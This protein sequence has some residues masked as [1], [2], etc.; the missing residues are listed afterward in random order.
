MKLQDKVTVITGAGS[1]IG[2]EMALL[3]SSEGSA[4]LAA[5][6]RQEAVDETARMMRD[7]M[8]DARIETFQV[9]VTNWEQ[10]QAMI[11]KAIDTFGRVDILCNNAGIGHI[12]DVLKV[13]E[14]TFDRVMDVNV[15]GPFWGTKA[16]VPH[17]LDR[18]SGIIINTA[19][20]AG[21][22]GLPERAIYCTSKGAVIALTKQVA[23]QYA[24]KGI[25]CN[26]ICPGTVDTP[27]VEN[28]LSQA[29]D[30]AQMRRNLIARQPLGRL[31]TP[32]EVAK[33][34]LYLASEDASFITGTALV[35]DGGITAQ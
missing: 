26:C 14:A 24:T 19:S 32:Q 10:V 28:L 13:D 35:I 4:I 1:G 3:F 20:V 30:P 31:G 16:V 5:D 33:A 21:M 6:V 34:A 23:V 25:R 9:D 15:K 12:G 11:K 8:P 18:G 7:K 17:M 2:R 29:D 27:W 22:I